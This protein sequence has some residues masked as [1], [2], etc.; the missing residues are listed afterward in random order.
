MTTFSTKWSEQR[1]AIRW[2]LSTN[3]KGYAFFLENWKMI[4]LEFLFK[5]MFVDMVLQW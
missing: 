5:V 2:R 4:L 1:V 3:R